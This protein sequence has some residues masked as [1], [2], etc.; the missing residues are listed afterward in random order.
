MHFLTDTGIPVPAVDAHAMR[1]V[2]RVAVEA[3]GVDILQMMENAGRALSKHALFLRGTAS[4][5]VVIVAGGGNNGG[6]GLCC[7]RHLHNRDIPIQVILDRPPSALHAL[8]QHQW[9]TLEKAGYT[10]ISPEKGATV[11]NKA[12]VI[13]DALIGYGLQGPP[14]Q[15]A[16]TLITQMNQSGRPILSLD[17]PSVLR[18]DVAVPEHSWVHAQR[19]LTLALPK[20][21]LRYVDGDLPG[22]YWHPA[23]SVRASWP[24]LYI[25]VWPRRLGEIGMDMSLLVKMGQCMSKSKACGLPPGRKSITMCS[26]I[27]KPNTLHKIEMMCANFPKGGTWQ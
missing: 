26:R 1:E 27:D 8:A 2:D 4:G 18:T 10:P 11:L 19:V 13:V 17:V 9:Y 23:G 3:F 22:R 20:P 12:A 7:A 24:G 25:A 15:P 6:G 14:R 5:P 21:A 16:A